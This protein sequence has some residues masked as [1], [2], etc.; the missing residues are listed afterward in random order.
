MAS[1][2]PTGGDGQ[3]PPPPTDEQLLDQFVRGRRDALGQ[4]AGRYE[5]ALLGLALGLLR[6]RHDLAVDAVQ[7]TWVRVIKYAGTFRGA[8][9]VKTWLYRIAINRCRDV[10]ADRGLESGA[11]AEGGTLTSADAAVTGLARSAEEERVESLRRAVWRLGESQ[12]LVLLLCYHHGF[13]HEQ[14]A[15]VLDVPL[16]TVK[17]RLAS[18]LSNLRTTLSEAARA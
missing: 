17:S 5:T 16:G 9:T 11:A 12:S 7:E 10:A 13:T 18:A 1:D 4:L 2:Q 6:G 8:S 3:G 14:V 15:A